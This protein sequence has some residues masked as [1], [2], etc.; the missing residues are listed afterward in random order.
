MSYLNRLTLLLLALSKI[1]IT[2]GIDNTTENIFFLP[3]DDVSAFVEYMDIQREAFG[4]GPDEHFFSTIDSDG[5]LVP[6]YLD[7]ICVDTNRTLVHRLSIADKPFTRLPVNDWFESIEPVRNLFAFVTDRIWSWTG[8]EYQM[9]HDE[10]FYVKKH[11]TSKN[12]IFFLHGINVMNGVENIPFLGSVYTNSTI[13]VLAYDP[14]F[15]FAGGKV[16][17]N[18]LWSHI[19]NLKNIISTIIETSV[20]QTS[21]DQTSVASRPMIT[22][23]G[24]SYGTLR[25]VSLC[26]RF[27]NLCDMMD[28]II[29]F[30]PITI[31]LPFSTLWDYV[32]DGVYRTTNR[33]EQCESP[34]HKWGGFLS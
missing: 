21:V 29:L 16:I 3:C 25:V 24:T 8:W 12:I 14:Q 18:S 9:M 26:K 34:P 4:I 11:P 20:D 27:P 32:H 31:N 23:I 10:Y 22:I 7:S 33:T 5:N 28:N 2:F 13:Y 15:V 1:T 19:N 17:Q 6:W 30:D